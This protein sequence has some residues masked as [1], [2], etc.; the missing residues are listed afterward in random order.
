MSDEGRGLG[1]LDI[2]QVPI[3]DIP[4]GTQFRR[5]WAPILTPLLKE[6][7]PGQ[8][9]EI[10]AMSLRDANLVKASWRHL[11]LRWRPHVRMIR[12]KGK[13][14][15]KVYVWVEDMPDMDED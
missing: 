13:E 2:K 9:Y 1:V 7:T 11:A 15:V 3:D 5:S 4:D 10:L 6:I 12:E 8:S 14:A